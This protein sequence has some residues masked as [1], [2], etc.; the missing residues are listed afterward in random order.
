MDEQDLTRFI[1]QQGIVAEL[2]LLDTETPTVQAAAA[3]VGVAPEQ[4]GKSILFM[5]VP[6]TCRLHVPCKFLLG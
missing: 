5:A 3:A 2:V 1:Q 6:C 4:I